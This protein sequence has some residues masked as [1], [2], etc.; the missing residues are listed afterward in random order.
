ML[1]ILKIFV[2][3]YIS[4]ILVITFIIALLLGF[5]LPK[6]SYENKTE[7]MLKKAVSS[8]DDLKK[9]R[10]YYTEFVISD[11]K[12]ID[13]IKINYNHHDKKN[14]IPLPATLVHDL[15]AILPEEN[16]KIK[17]LS[18]YPF[19][20]RKDRVLDEFEKKSIS[21]LENNPG[22]VFNRLVENK[23]GE[24]EFRVAV[25][26]VF[27]DPTCVNCHNTR[28][29]T[30]KNDWK[31]GDVRGVIEVTMPMEN[32]L[33]LNANQTIYYLFILVFLLLILIIHYSVLSFN[34]KK[35]HYE[36]KTKLEKEVEERTSKLQSTVTLLNQYK[37][38]V[39][40][41]AIVSKTDK[42]GVITYTNEEFIKI[43]K[44]TQEELIGQKHNLIKHEDMP[45]EVFKDLWKTISAK[46]IWKGIIKNKDK[47]GLAY[48]VASTIVPILN[49]D[50]E[51][52][53]FLA[54]RLDITD[55]IESQLRAKRADEVKS[56]FLANMSHEIRTPLN[57]ILGFSSILE[58]NTELSKESRKQAKVIQTS[59]SSLLEIINDILDISKIQSG[60]FDIS[61]E[62]TDLYY[63]TEN[64]V[65]LFSK[66]ANEK[67]I[68]LIF[69]LDYKI[70]LCIMA[71]GGRIRQVLSNLLSNAIKFTQEHGSVYINIDLIEQK[72][73]SALIR[74]D[75]IDNGI[76]IPKEK[77]NHIFEPF[78]QVD[79]K[80]NRL[81][82]GT[83][84]GLSI[85][86]HIIK[87]FNSR[88]DI[89]SHVGRGTKFTFD[90]EFETC[91]KLIHERGEF[92]DHLNFKVSDE[93]SELFHFIK[94]YASIFGVLNKD[95]DIK[96]DVAIYS[97][98]SFE[99]LEQYREN[100][101]TPMLVLFE[102]ENQ[103]KEIEQK[104]NEVFISLPFYASKVNDALQELL[105]ENTPSLK[106]EDINE[107][108]TY[109]GKI[110]VAE[111][112]LANQELITYVLDSFN[113]DFDIRANGLET[114]NSY[115]NDSTYDLILMD[116]NMPILD[117]VG[118]F[119]QI[120]EFEKNSKIAETP[121]IALTA[122]AIKGDKEKFLS[123]GMD[124]YL[125]KPIN[126]RELSSI[127]EIYL[128]GNLNKKKAH[129]SVDLEKIA[130]KLGI[131]QNIA[132]LLTNK[133]KED[134]SKDLEELKQN[135]DE[136]EQLKI[137]SKAHYIKN[138]ALN[139]CLDDI[140]K[141]LEKLEYEDLAQEKR[142][143][144]YTELE[145]SIKDLE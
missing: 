52:E 28:A 49:I 121:V 77:L 2:N 125:S 58:K 90:I 84:L 13:D 30:P 135:I 63:I 129:V 118:A 68:K 101:N 16:I 27:Y 134:I 80:S 64:V 44:Y 98:S 54:I 14:V 34:R 3:P 76:G 50:D 42:R 111:D 33:L 131:T 127:F 8:T 36:A 139:L 114:V 143:S 88:I 37:K 138:S 137:A 57:A 20:N 66:K 9:I 116:I 17:M 89:E 132:S 35:E 25:A 104:E 39:D 91:Q 99:E 128:K 7:Q 59:A 83:G 26:D 62:E 48:Y 79:H 102:Y 56:T 126:T 61:I 133:F 94:R 65:E 43:S 117:G 86:S 40:F 93:K 71:D 109:K 100:N 107:M 73:D 141:I 6:L 21:F 124:G 123:L 106:N 72:D 19:P 5:V 31:L 15:S 47:D 95:K 18:N 1:K 92:L 85:C 38:A 97:F 75:V 87:S 41:S 53:E 105:K 10:S 60:K 122:N 145:K 113:L 22:E 55:I 130:S 108:N 11:I 4:P 103:E 67:H 70:P 81:Y 69:N 115:R 78:I 136:E 32:G 140:V 45:Q 110:L 12:K 144:L 119:K 120:R 23:E 29:D 96:D 51:I 142:L 24:S 82:E 74:F 112:N 46:K